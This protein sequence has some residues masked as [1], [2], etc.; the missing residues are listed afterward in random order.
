MRA[1][2]R[3]WQGRPVVEHVTPNQST[4]T[5]LPHEQPTPPLHVFYLLSFPRRIP[6]CFTIHPCT[7]NFLKNLRF[8]SSALLLVLKNTPNSNLHVRKQYPSS[9]VEEHGYAI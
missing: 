2:D 1:G 6:L 3:H 4:K 5:L 9:K 8:P 7:P